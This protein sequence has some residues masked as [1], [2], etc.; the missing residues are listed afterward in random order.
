MKIRKSIAL[1]LFLVLVL[2]A[3]CVTSIDTSRNIHLKFGNPSRANSSDINNYLIERTQYALSYN[4]QTGT[5]NWVSWQLN[6]SWL[7]SVDRSNDF[8]PDVELPEGCYQV[9]P[10]D[11]HRTGYDRGHLIPS[12]DR[13]NRQADNSATFLMSNMI[14]Q[15]PANNRDVW[16]KVERYCRELADK[17]NELYIIAGG[18]GKQETIAAGKVTVPKYTWKVIL[19]L[20][21]D[22]KVTQNASAF[23]V[24]MPNTE[25]VIDRNWRDYLV[26]IDNVEKQT[27][28]DF[29]SN[30]PT[31]IQKSIEQKIAI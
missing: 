18:N 8:R 21:S 19:V 27:G 29:F 6:S 14:P 7:G 1:L 26:S 3:G 15:S 31:K 20:D 5:A 24:W 2:V 28:Y 11:Y 23:A 16:E 17:D 22:F 13:T 12:G 10:G 4:C 9:N 25:E 30:L